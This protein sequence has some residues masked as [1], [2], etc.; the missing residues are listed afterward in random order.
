MFGVSGAW[1][2]WIGLCELRLSIA[3][4][5]GP[6][7]TLV[8]LAVRR[9]RYGVYGRATIL[10]VFDRA[11]VGLLLPPIVKVPSSERDFWVHLMCYIVRLLVVLQNMAFPSTFN[12]PPNCIRDIQKSPKAHIRLIY[13][14]LKDQKLNNN[15]TSSPSNNPTILTKL[16]LEAQGNPAY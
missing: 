2:G 1:V 15:F 14:Y 16:Q 12:R 5:D 4:F 7:Y 11:A 8:H 3:W 10:L 6:H 9:D 13:V